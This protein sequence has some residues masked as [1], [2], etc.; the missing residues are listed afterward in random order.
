[1]KSL[2]KLKK[3]LTNKK[4]NFNLLNDI[5]INSF[6]KY[7]NNI[8]HYYVKNSD[9]FDVES[10]TFIEI[11][12]GKGLNLNTVQS[13]SP[14][15]SALHLAVK[16]KK[17]EILRALLNFDSK[18]DI[19]DENGNTPLWEAVMGY[20]NDDSFF[21]ETLIEKGADKNIENSHGV[22]PIGLSNII[23]NYDSTKF[24]K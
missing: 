22:S 11:L 8:L 9:F 3:E 17:K 1:M 23:A 6:D 21:I 12:V 18:I 5:D 14:H 2:E 10:Q 20:R 16:L 4:F 7:G 19:Q 15:S 13:K 24:L